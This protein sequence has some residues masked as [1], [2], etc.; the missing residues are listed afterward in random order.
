[1]PKKC[2]KCGVP[3][4]GFLSKISALAGVRQSLKNADYCNKCEHDAPKLESVNVKQDKAPEQIKDTV[5]DLYDTAE[6]KEKAQAQ[7]PTHHFDSNQPAKESN[8]LTQQEKWAQE[9]KKEQE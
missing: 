5:L 7:K 6:A 2:I 3:I 4:T 9:L 1:M 8:D